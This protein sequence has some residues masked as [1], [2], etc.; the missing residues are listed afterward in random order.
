MDLKPSDE[1]TLLWFTLALS[2]L[3][4]WSEE[5]GYTDQGQYPAT[6]NPRGKYWEIKTE[7]TSCASFSMLLG[8][9]FFPKY[10]LWLIVQWSTISGNPSGA[11]WMMLIL[12]GSW[13]MSH[14]KCAHQKPQEDKPWKTMLKTNTHPIS[15]PY[16]SPFKRNPPRRNRTR[17]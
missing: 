5:I 1:M 13:W 6:H 2:V 17:S 15:T 7:I 4:L 8:L 9:F 11:E 3:H 16:P 14:W 12:D 10:V